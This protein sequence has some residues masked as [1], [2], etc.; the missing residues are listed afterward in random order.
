MELR[1]VLG[2]AVPVWPRDGRVGPSGTDR[3]GTGAA[4]PC[5][6]LPAAH[7]AWLSSGTPRAPELPPACHLLGLFRRSPRIYLPQD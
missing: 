1:H 4:R 3:G 5:R 6:A 7:T 2:G